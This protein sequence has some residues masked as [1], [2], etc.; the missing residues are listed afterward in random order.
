MDCAKYRTCAAQK[1][2]KIALKLKNNFLVDSS[3]GRPTPVSSLT[4]CR[5]LAGA[6]ANSAGSRDSVPEW[7]VYRRQSGTASSSASASASASARGIEE[8]IGGTSSPTAA[9][10]AVTPAVVSSPEGLVHL[11]TRTA[12][13]K[14][15]DGIYIVDSGSENGKV[16]SI[17]DDAVNGAENAIGVYGYPLA[18]VLH[19]ITEALIDGQALETLYQSSEQGSRQESTGSVFNPCVAKAGSGGVPQFNLSAGQCRIDS[20]DEESD[21]P[22]PI[23]RRNQ[24]AP[25]LISPSFQPDDND[26]SCQQKSVLT[27]RG[28]VLGNNSI[29]SEVPLRL[30][31]KTLFDTL[32]FIVYNCLHDALWDD[33]QKSE[34]WDTYWQFRWIARQPVQEEDFTLFRVLGRGGFGMVNMCKRAQSGKLFAIK[35][36]NKKRIKM[37]QNVTLPLKER[38]HLACID[39]PY[40]VCL[41]FAFTTQQDVYL[42]VDLMMGGDMSF[43]LHRKGHFALGE[44]KYFAAR[45]LMGVMAL[46]DKEIIYRDLKPDN[47]LMDSDGYTRI[48][49]LG[50][51]TNIPRAGLS[52]PC[53]TR[54]YWAP[55]MLRKDSNGKREKYYKQVDWFSF[56]CVV[57]EFLIG[58]CPFRTSKARNWKLNVVQGGPRP[59]KEEREQAIDLAIKEMEPD[60]DPGVFRDP[61]T[62]QFIQA[63]LH[64]NP[65]QRLGCD[66]G[67]EVYN[68]AWFKDLDWE[69]LAV[70]KPP[71]KP[72]RNINMAPQ[73]EIG[74][75][76]DEKESTKVVLTAE[77]HRRYENWGFVNPDAFEEEVVM[78]LRYKELVSYCTILSMHQVHVVICMY[79][80]FISLCFV[81][82]CL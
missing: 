13:I 54:G 37:K 38:Q 8:P 32:D 34:E 43:H 69:Q 56:G 22:T 9:P 79:I 16:G 21:I 15:V 72:A 81:M 48:S 12:P 19:V 53:G 64:K 58:C 18:E 49:D 23:V 7:R 4:L 82:M 1:R 24:Q 67:H 45:I 52:G 11:P 71:W 75:F 25:L 3:S 47:I 36:M 6:S 76:S 28:I 20:D 51:A 62:V 78:Y 55:E 60:F 65:Q 31:P 42:V 57:Y 73:Q 30:L 46:H 39:S 29:S 63:L 50:L 5:I 35:M 40:V 26:N 77:D 10:A 74:V 17:S 27:E 33:F 41:K 44:T 68:H 59:T 14:T 80:Y 70:M 2:L 66:G 61:V